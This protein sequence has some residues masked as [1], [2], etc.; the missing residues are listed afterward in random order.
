MTQGRVET[1]EVVAFAQQSVAQMGY[2]Y[3]VEGAIYSGFFM[4]QFGDSRTPGNMW[5]V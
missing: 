4:Q 2:S 3:S 1:A 5:I